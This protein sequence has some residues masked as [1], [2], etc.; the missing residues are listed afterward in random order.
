[1]PNEIESIIDE[2]VNSQIRGLAVKAILGKAGDIT[3]DQLAGLRDS[4][5]YGAVMKEVSLQELI[6]AYVDTNHL[7]EGVAMDDAP[8]ATVVS[9]PASGAGKKKS[10]RRKAS[11]RNGAASRKGKGGGGG[12]AAPGRKVNFRDADAKEKYASHVESEIENRGGE[13]I[14]TTELTDLCGGSSNQARD[15]LQE[16][17]KGGRVICTGLARATRYYWRAGAT[18]EVI[19]EFE[20]NVPPSQQPAGPMSPATPP[21]G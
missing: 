19:A 9:R 7:V 4:E 20:A 16:L 2:G 15:I 11:P 21:S 17:V 6:D 12:S 8:V 14:S 10:A 3:L 5:R 18:P 13:P 1:M